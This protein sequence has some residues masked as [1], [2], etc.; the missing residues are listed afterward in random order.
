VEITS[1]SEPE[2]LDDIRELI[3]EF[4]AWTLAT[5]HAG[6]PVVPPA[7]TRLED[8]LATLPG[9]YAP[10]DGALFLASLAGRRAGCVVSFRHD[11]RSVEVSRLWVRPEARGRGVGALLVQRALETAKA[12]GYERAVLRS[13][14]KMTAAHDVYRS[15]GFRRM[16]G[17][18][19][20]PGILDVAIAM[21]RPLS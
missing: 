15:A 3:R 11:P 2:D 1:A 13:H 7:F 20:F 8:E 14:G 5:F 21:E 19:E 6:D 4:S 18:K 9:K 10:P 16:D 17:R 12:A